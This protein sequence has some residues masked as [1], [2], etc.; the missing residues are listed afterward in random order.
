MYF[1]TSPDACALST[2]EAPRAFCFQSAKG[3]ST[4]C[5]RVRAWMR[6]QATT[7]TSKHRRN[8]PRSR[9]I[10]T[11]AMTHARCSEHLRNIVYLQVPNPIRNSAQC[12][13]CVCTAIIVMAP[14]V[15]KVLH[16]CV[17]MDIIIM[18]PTPPRGLVSKWYY[19]NT[20]RED[21]RLISGQYHTAAR[22]GALIV[23]RIHRSTLQ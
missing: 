18:T 15:R 21:T 6:A 1:L 2:Q 8:D 16:A 9:D 20:R 10:T 14:I 4:K 12:S 7:Y 11:T 3:G 5:L 19:C 13:A 23:C 17:Y 22:E